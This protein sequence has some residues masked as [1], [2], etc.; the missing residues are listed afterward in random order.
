MNGL[1]R[2]VPPDG[3]VEFRGIKLVGIPAE[4]G[5]KLLFSLAFFLLTALIGAG[6]GL[7]RCCFTQ[8]TLKAAWS[9]QSVPAR[10]LRLT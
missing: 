9:F 8:H 6:S 5:K 2:I 1:I 10:P 4:N 3:A 7:C